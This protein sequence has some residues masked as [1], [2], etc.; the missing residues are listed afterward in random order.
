MSYSTGYI[1]TELV[2]ELETSTLMYDNDVRK[3][4]LNKF[5]ENSIRI[6]YFI[7]SRFCIELFVKKGPCPGTAL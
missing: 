7:C 5:I 4:E 1:Y 6:I 3:C 2:G